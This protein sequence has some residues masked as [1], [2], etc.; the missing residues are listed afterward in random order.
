MVYTHEGGLQPVVPPG[1]VERSGGG[2]TLGPPEATAAPKPARPDEPAPAHVEPDEAELAGEQ[3]RSLT[4]TAGH[5]QEEA[6]ALGAEIVDTGGRWDWLEAHHPVEVFVLRAIQARR[7]GRAARTVTGAGG[8]GFRQIV[9]ELFPQGDPGQPEFG[10]LVPLERLRHR[11][12]HRALN[13]TLD[14]M[15]EPAQ[16]EARRARGNPPPTFGPG[17]RFVERQGA[18]GMMRRLE[19]LSEGELLNVLEEAYRRVRVDHPDMLS[20]DTWEEIHQAFTRVRG[21]L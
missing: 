20:P 10:G 8:E 14:Q 13:D 16:V 1:S 18:A 11:D 9:D 17:S 3:G 5:T 6:A 7:M 15:L 21:T 4:D 19:G 2:G 12:F